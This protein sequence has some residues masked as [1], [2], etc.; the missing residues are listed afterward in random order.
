MRNRRQI[1]V[2]NAAWILPA[3]VFAAVASPGT[4]VATGSS[5]IPACA[6]GL[7]PLV[8]TSTRAL[9]NGA[10]F[11]DFEVAGATET[12]IQPPIGFDSLAATD[13]ELATYRLPSRPTDPQAL[14]AWTEAM[15]AYDQSPPT[16]PV[17]CTDPSVRFSVV[18]RD[19]NYWTGYV[20][21]SPYHFT[22]VQANVLQP[23]NYS[24][25]NAS[26]LTGQWVGIGGYGNYYLL[27]TG[28]YE[29]QNT[30]HGTAF[31]EFLGPGGLDSGVR[32]PSNWTIAWGDKLYVS[33]Q[34]NTSTRTATTLVQDITHPNKW[35][36][37]LSGADAY[38]SP[39]SVEYIAEVP[40]GYDAQ[41]VSTIHFSNGQGRG[42]DGAW[43][44]VATGSSLYRLSQLSSQGHFF[45]PTG[46]LSTGSFDINWSTCY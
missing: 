7:V 40:H 14:E 46:F 12:L 9:A 6:G 4:S 8:P 15:I 31:Y 41:K 33:V 37:S 23:T 3:I 22:A 21:T 1:A 28:S 27:Q 24:G 20:D 32:G 11:Y 45:T 36:G 10:R 29:E 43:H 44:G 19:S 17:I 18:A 34:Y 35:Q 42:L 5:D 26:P 25:C 39:S 16:V 13:V 30:Q 38:Y 2:R